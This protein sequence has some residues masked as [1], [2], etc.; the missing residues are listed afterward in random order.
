MFLLIAQIKKK[1]IKFA[2]KIMKKLFT[3]FLLLFYFSIGFSQVLLNR[4]CAFEDILRRT[5]MQYHLDD[6]SLHE[7]L[8]DQSNLRIVGAETIYVIQTEVHLVY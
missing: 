2:K 5:N 6:E 7:Q 8:K 1:I 3:L 4:N